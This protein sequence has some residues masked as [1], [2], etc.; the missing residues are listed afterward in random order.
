MEFRDGKS[1]VTREKIQ[2]VDFRKRTR[3]KTRK[4]TREETREE[5][6][7]VASLLSSPTMAPHRRSSPFERGGGAPRGVGPR[8][9]Y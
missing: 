1:C 4:Q 9:D 6:T 8:V 7:M 2:R 5:T 3:E